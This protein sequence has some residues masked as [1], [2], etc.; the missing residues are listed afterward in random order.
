[1]P[2]ESE[3]IQKFPFEP[4]QIQKFPL[5]PEQKQNFPLESELKKHEEWRH[6]IDT[7]MHYETKKI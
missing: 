3:Q 5:E 1:L 7:G 2:L 6:S 4:E